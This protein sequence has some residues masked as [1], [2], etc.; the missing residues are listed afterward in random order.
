MKPPECKIPDLDKVT[1]TGYLNRE[2]Q[3]STANGE[4][5]AIVQKQGKETIHKKIS[6]KDQIFYRRK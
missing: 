5:V 1:M 4:E 6:N 3:I 2:P